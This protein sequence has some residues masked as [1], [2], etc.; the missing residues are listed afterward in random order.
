MELVKDW[1]GGICA[2][3]VIVSVIKAIS[4]KNPAGKCVQ[5][6]GA[7]VLILTVISPFKSL[8]VSDIVI[9]D[10]R[11][12]LEFEEKS[13]NLQEENENIQ[14]EIIEDQIAAY[15]SQRL[16]DFDLGGSH[17]AVEIVKGQDGGIYPDK[18]KIL[19]DKNV[20]K[21]ERREIEGIIKRECG[22]LKD[23]IVFESK[24]GL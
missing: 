17:V 7:L 22:V 5:L 10:R 8:S 2:V 11:C 18:V 14:K 20:S 24:G 23:G 6:V 19:T 9:N 21:S 15:I 4:P 3:A 1:I 12:E 13:L 16:L